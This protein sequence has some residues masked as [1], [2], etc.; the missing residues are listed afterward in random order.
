MTTPSSEAPVADAATADA[1][2]RPDVAVFILRAQPFHFGHQ[3]VIRRALEQARHVVLLLGSALQPRTPMNPFTH[4]E[5]AAMIRASFDEADNAR[6]QIVP[7]M[8]VLYND[9]AWITNIRVAV[10]RVMAR[11]EPDRPDPEIALIGHSKDES[12]YY[13]RL[14]PEWQSIDCDNYRGI[15]ATD[16]RR[17]IF[18]AGGDLSDDSAPVLETLREVTP[19]PVIWLLR[20]FMAQ[21]ELANVVEEDR[22][23]Q[24]YKSGWAASPY[25][26]TFVTVAAVVV[27][28]GHVL[29]IKRNTRPGL[30]QTALPGGFVREDESLEDGVIRE[31][32]EDTR[33]KVPEAVLRGSIRSTDVFD[34]PKRSARGRTIAHAHLIQLRDST[35]LPQVRGSEQRP[36]AFWLPFHQ[37]DPQRMFEA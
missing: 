22:F 12:S 6:I 14:F 17:A 9:P 2:F 37:L 7:L 5:R 36:V 11:I 29:L 20:N 15:N 28:S 32:R 19:E 33:I 26:P 13:L 8:D 10:Q 18:D 24:N 23:I 35:S 21:P 27:Q 30:G 31:L 3:S 16:L 34:Y 25:P 1:D 4:N